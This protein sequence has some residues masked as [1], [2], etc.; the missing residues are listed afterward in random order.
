MCIR[1]SLQSALNVGLGLLVYFSYSRSRGFDSLALARRRCGGGGLVA[2]ALSVVGA[3]RLRHQLAVDDRVRLA[4]AFEARPPDGRVDGVR[5]RL[6]GV[7]YSVLGT[8][9]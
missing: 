2:A 3:G 1:D 9:A 4:P 7:S 5:G 8:L 6:L